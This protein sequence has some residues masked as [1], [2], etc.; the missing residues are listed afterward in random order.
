MIF[1]TGEH[2]ERLQA[3]DAEFLIKIVVGHEGARGDFELPGGEVEDLL[4][5]LF[6]GAHIGSI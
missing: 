1:E 3:V 2:F 6:D 4:R 5:G